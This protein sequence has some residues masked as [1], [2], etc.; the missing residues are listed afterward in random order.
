[1]GFILHLLKCPLVL[2]TDFSF[3]PYCLMYLL[4]T[5]AIL[6]NNLDTFYL[7]KI[8]TFFLP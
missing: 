7:L 4:M 2:L 1:M 5:F 6:F 8:L 3:G